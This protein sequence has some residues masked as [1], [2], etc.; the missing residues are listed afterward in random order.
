MSILWITLLNDVVS[1]WVLGKLFKENE[2]Y[3]QLSV[4]IHKVMHKFFVKIKAFSTDYPQ[5]MIFVRRALLCYN[6]A[7][8]NKLRNE[9][10]GKHDRKCRSSVCSY[11]VLLEKM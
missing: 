9:V 8:K 10:C 1:L 11:S 6:N 2:K 7:T 3:P 4:D 5:N